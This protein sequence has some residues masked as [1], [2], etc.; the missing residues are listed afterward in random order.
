MN[1]QE[2]TGE[3]TCVLVVEKVAGFCLSVCPARWE[4]GVSWFGG[5]YEEKVFSVLQVAVREERTL[6]GG[7]VWGR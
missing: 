1:P 6:C 5:P 7:S 3:S 4:A 2:E